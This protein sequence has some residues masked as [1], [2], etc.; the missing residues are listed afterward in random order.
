MDFSRAYEILEQ[1]GEHCVACGDN[2]VIDALTIGDATRP[3]RGRSTALI[4]APAS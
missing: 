1:V 4:L 2:E 3:G